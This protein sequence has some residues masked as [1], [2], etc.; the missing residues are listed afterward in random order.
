MIIYREARVERAL[1]GSSDYWISIQGIKGLRSVK[2]FTVLMAGQALTVY[3]RY[4][5]WMIH[6]IEPM[7]KD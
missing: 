4:G 6:H 2:N 7:K 1:A 3:W 5:R